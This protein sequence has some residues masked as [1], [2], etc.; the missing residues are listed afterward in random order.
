MKQHAILIETHANVDLLGRVLK[1]MEAENHYFFIHVDKKTS[2]YNE[3]LALKSD[4]VIFTS[5]RFDVKWGSEEQIYLTIELLQIAKQFPIDF[6]YYH[7]IS[8]QDYPIKNNQTFDCFFNKTEKS[9]MELDWKN[10]IPPRLMFYHFNGLLDVKKKGIGEKLERHCTN[11]QKYISKY[12]LLRKPLAQKLYKGSNWWSLH[13]KLVDYILQY[14]N[15]NPNYLKRFHFTSCCD[16]IFFHTI[17]FNSPLKE[18]IELTDLRY[19][20]WKQTYPN[21]TLPRTLTEKDYD[22]IINSKSFFC[23]KVNYSISRQLIELLDNN[24]K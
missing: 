14:I 20:D 4:H 6:D 11:L 15:S 16:E 10:P 8:G 19:Y 17:A 21:E 7:L 23:R 22:S 5:K 1:K 12:I 24:E 13:N 2:N 18:T 9:F 3:F